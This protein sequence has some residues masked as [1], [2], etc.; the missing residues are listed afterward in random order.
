MSSQIEQLMDKR[1]EDE[2]EKSSLKSDAAGADQSA[3]PLQ[4]SGFDQMDCRDPEKQRYRE[5]GNARCRSCLRHGKGSGQRVTLERGTGFCP[6]LRN[7]R[8]AEICG[9]VRSG[10]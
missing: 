1:L 10:D 7:H 9:N 3:F 8:E 5:G 6:R 2:K 4:H